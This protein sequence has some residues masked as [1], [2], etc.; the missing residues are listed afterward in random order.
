M[1]L[2]PSNANFGLP[3]GSG[4]II[5]PVSTP[6]GPESTEGSTTVPLLT[7]P[8]LTS[9]SLESSSGSSVTFQLNENGPISTA[10]VVVL[11][12]PE[13]TLNEFIK[14]VTTALNNLRD[15]VFEAE[16]QNNLTLRNM[17]LDAILTA[18]NLAAKY[19]AARQVVDLQQ[20][21]FDLVSPLVQE[22]N[23]AIDIYITRVNNTQGHPGEEQEQIDAMNEAIAQFNAKEI[24]VD[25]YIEFFN[26]YFDYANTRNQILSPFLNAVNTAID[27]YNSQLPQANLLID[28]IN[29]ARATLD[30]PPLPHQEPLDH[31][32]PLTLPILPGGG[33][34][35]SDEDV[36]LPFIPDR[37]IPEHATPPPPPPPAR[38]LVDESFTQEFEA[39]VPPIISFQDYLEVITK[40]REYVQFVLSGR[41]KVM[42]N[43]YIEPLPGAF[44]SSTG[45]SSA[46][47]G[48]SLGSLSTGL[49]NPG[50]EKILG[51]AIYESATLKF[52][53]PMPAR[54]LA[55]LIL[56]GLETL[57]VS[58][59][60]ATIPAMR[61]VANKLPFID[62]DR[63]A[64]DVF[65]GLTYSTHISNFIAAEDHLL[66]IQDFARSAFPGLD[67][68]QRQQLAG[69][70]TAGLNLSLLQFA[71]FQLSQTLGIPGLSPQLLASAS[72]Q[73]VQD[74]IQE[75]SG[76]PT[77]QDTLQNPLTVAS[78]KDDLSRQLSSSSALSESVRNTAI[79]EAV[80]NAIASREFN[81]A[82]D[83][84]VAL[85]RELQRKEIDAKT[86]NRLAAEAVD[87]LNAETFGLYLLDTELKRDLFNKK[88]LSDRLSAEGI[89]ATIAGTAI[90]KVLQEETK[91]LRRLRDR[92]ADELVAQNVSRGAAL[93][94]ATQAVIG[95]Q[96]IG[97]PPVSGL[98]LPELISQRTVALLTPSVGVDEAQTIANQLNVTLFGPPLG[99]EGI[100]DELRRPTSIVNQIADQLRVLNDLHDATVQRAVREQIREFNK[101]NFDLFT[102]NR[103]VMDPANTLLLSM[104]TGVMY[105]GEG[106]FPSNYQQTIDVI[107]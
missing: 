52:S 84:R 98:P 8:L 66:M 1:S 81:S 42:P 82:D 76:P 21:Y 83:L 85:L 41:V 61:L 20:Q 39:Q 36:I 35:G 94:A 51:A 77:F 69:A 57:S 30:L 18:Q 16:N 15:T 91:S 46:G 49:Y 11:P 32:E 31:A 6:A 54:L 99:T 45:V 64:S 72:G 47:A 60:Q 56:T 73:P 90:D 2:D 29:E 38:Q 28:Q 103:R 27:E 22:V 34:K 13:I 63:S 89:N 105:K 80:N 75:F 37:V 5:P 19:T 96:R 24:T 78:L 79:N 67:D 106:R 88:I 23:G 9:D 68:A 10:A 58:G 102:F 93:A 17:R 40:Y 97:P 7:D 104:W 59:L 100:K 53:T 3:P 62:V 65:L 55:T 107:I 71:T 50:L 12:L 95:D 92:V 86:A 44:F 4:S 25:E 48:V 70:L 26:E 33:G 87:F 43:G 74:I 101:P 14:T